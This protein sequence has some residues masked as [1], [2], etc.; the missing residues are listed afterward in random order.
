MCMCIPF[1]S[2][3]TWV[4]LSPSSPQPEAWEPEG[5]ARTLAVASN[6]LFW[7]EISHV[8][9]GI[10]WNHQS[11]LRVTAPSAPIT[12]ST[13][14]ALTSLP[15]PA[16]PSALGISSTFRVPFSDVAVAWNDH[17]H[18]HYLRLISHHQFVS[19][20]LEVLRYLDLLILNHVWTCLPCDVLRNQHTLMRNWNRTLME[21]ILNKIYVMS[22]ICVDTISYIWCIFQN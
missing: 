12:I 9:P 4:V 7:T 5:S 14:A 10:C 2:S 21:H 22:D 13:T 15:F 3:P 8:P 11:S 20:D 18:H 17:I 16:L 19:L 6:V 1:C